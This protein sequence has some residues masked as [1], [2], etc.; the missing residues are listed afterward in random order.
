LVTRVVTL[1]GLPDGDVDLRVPGLPLGSDPGT[2]RAEV[3]GGARRVVA[4]SAS[5][6]VPAGAPTVGATLAEIERIE[7]EIAAWRD[8]AGW[9]VAER[10]K[11]EAVRVAP[12]LRPGALDG[13]VDERLA[14]ALFASGLVSA[15]EEQI[16]ARIAALEDELFALER[17]LDAARLAD[18][19]TSS[20]ARR[21]PLHPTRTATVRLEGSG[22][23]EGLSLS[24]VVRAARWWPAYTL[25]VRDGGTKAAWQKEAWVAQRSGEDWSGV[26][27]AL[28]TADMI[29]DARLPELPSLRIGR[30]TPAR[31]RRGYRPAPSGLDALFAGYARAFDDVSRAV[32]P[33]AP[34]P[35]ITPLVEAA[36][37][38]PV[39]EGRRRDK[40]RPR[41][42]TTVSESAA[43]PPA[44]PPPALPPPLPPPLVFPSMPA[45]VPAMGASPPG[46]PPMTPPMAI[47]ASAA[48]SQALAR[49]RP[50]AAA[51]ALSLDVAVGGAAEGAPLM[52]R[53]E[54][55]VD[56][57]EGAES[58]EPADQWLHFDRL[59]LAENDDRARRGRLVP[60]APDA[61]EG[62][63]AQ[64]ESAAPAG[65]CD[66]SASRGFF[67]HAWDAAGRVQIPS[68]GLAHRVSVAE[69]EGEARSRYRTVPR[70]APEVYR[71][72]VVKNP[73]GAPLLA[74]PVDVYVGGALLLVAHIGG[75]DTGGTF[76]VGLGVEERLRVA[77][78]VRYE[79]KSAGFL[80]GSTA[81]EAE[82]TIELRSSLGHAVEVEVLDRHPIA[83]D[84]DLEVKLVSSTPPAQ[85]YDQTDRGRP[86]A[87]GLRFFVKLPPAGTGEA[88]FSYRLTHAAKMEIVGGSRRG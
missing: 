43:P 24:Y 3:R 29:L 81:T 53:A 54:G 4:V 62:D 39:D 11:L 84:G 47:P 66:P 64:L 78:N 37:A 69:A 87:G 15:I 14:D 72:L 44:P 57:R 25:R 73:F 70:E 56:A 12:R 34:P 19:Q 32:S 31:E 42:E 65:A 30:A 41:G 16:D 86:I 2:L 74:G 71:E 21:G 23:P 38:A 58:I 77:R 20:V 88:R 59:I 85:P 10:R 35:A 49:K 76:T 75:V 52:E 67:D 61:V 83:Q 79:E 46:G 8:E 40:R 22:A 6:E 9:L 17:A 33:G 27:L 26:A 55:T 5:V 50:A 36:V 28:S 60:A 51:M 82:V 18:A 13:H 1:A 48:P 63:A 45:A 80:G 7:D 68:D